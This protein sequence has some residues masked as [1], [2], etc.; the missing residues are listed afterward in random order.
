MTLQVAAAEE[1]GGAD[2]AGEGFLPG[3]YSHVILHRRVFG[4]SHVAHVADEL[5]PY[6][7]V[8]FEMLLQ[9]HLVGEHSRAHGALVPASVYFVVALEELAR[10]EVYFAFGAVM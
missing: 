10:R 3:V 2:F 6:F 8:L 7:V 1:G 5:V 9:Y 4:E